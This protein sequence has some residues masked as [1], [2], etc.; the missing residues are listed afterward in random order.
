MDGTVLTKNR[1]GAVAGVATRHLA[2]PEAESLGLLGAGQQAHAQLEAISQVINLDRVVLSDPDEETVEQFIATE[3]DRDCE[4]VVRSPKMV[5]ECD[6]ISTTTP[7]TEPILEAAWFDSETH[8][9]A[10]GADAEGKQELETELVQNANVVVDDWQQCSH[11]GEINTAVSSGELS[12]DD[13]HA[14]LDEVVTTDRDRSR[15]Q[16]TVFDSTGLAIQDVA[17]ANIVYQTAV[18]ND[19]GTELELV[20]S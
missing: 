13:V 10:M 20:R 5:A 19:I 8:I 7:S 11:S 17:T 2:P 15:G 4:F 16:V 18:D 14:T 12:Q 9:N 3:S 1:T 6:I